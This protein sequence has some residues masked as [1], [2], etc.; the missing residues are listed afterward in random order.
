M[1]VKLVTIEIPE[2]SLDIIKAISE[3]YQSDKDINPFAVTK[4]T[5]F[6]WT[7]VKKQ[8]NNNFNIKE[9]K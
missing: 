8:L 6:S 2:K 9:K 3:L 1:Q 4:V 7:Y 5:N